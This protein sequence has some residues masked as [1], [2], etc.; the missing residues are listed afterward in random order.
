MVIT[1]TGSTGTIGGELLRLLSE[2]GRREAGFAVRAVLR[3]PAKLRPLEGVAWT[4]ADLR[5]PRLREAALAGTER[6]FLL[7]GNEAGFARMQSGVVRAARALGVPLIVK[8]SALGASSHSNS[9]IARE[10]WEVEQVLQEPGT[11]W[12]I[13][14]PHAFM[15]NW[16]GEVAEGVRE[17]GVIESPV[18]DG[19]VPFIDAR[20]IA[21][22][23]AEAL[24]HPEAHAGRRWFLTGGEAVGY[25]DLAAAVS[26]ATGRPVAYRPLS[27]EEARARLEAQGLPAFAVDSLLAI[28]AYQRAGGPTSQVSDKVER[29]LGRP[30]RTIR[31]FVRDHLA[32]FTPGGR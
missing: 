17:R 32:A 28:A 26:E 20:D 30:P 24:L 15:Q 13:L 11:G 29:L 6:L 19:R 5:D 1:V 25:A 3:D 31:D 21:A 14:R 16:L 22:V 9:P 12:T 7:S 10:H 23:A 18:G 2:A 8:L 4:R 27:M